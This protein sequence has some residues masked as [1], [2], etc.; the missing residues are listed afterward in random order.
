MLMMIVIVIVM[1]LIQID[2]GHWHVKHGIRVEE[3][4]IAKVH[5]LW[6]TT[7][8]LIWIWQEQMRRIDV[9]QELLVLA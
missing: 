2:V 4:A 6:H 9:I 8:A 7:Q 3:I 1:M 5:D